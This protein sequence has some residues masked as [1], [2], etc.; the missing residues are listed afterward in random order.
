MSEVQYVNVAYDVIANDLGELMFVMMEVPEGEA[1]E[2]NIKFVYDGTSKAMFVRSSGQIARLPLLEPKIC[3]MLADG[4]KKIY[5]LE[6]AG[7]DK[8]DV[9]YFAPIEVLNAP[10]PI[11][12]LIIEGNVFEKDSIDSNLN[13][14]GKITLADGVVLEGNFV[15]GKL[16]GKGKMTF[17]DGDIYEGDFVDGI[18]QGKGKYT[19]A[20][21]D[22]RE[23]DF[24]DGVMNGKGK[25][26]FADGDMC[27]G[28]FVNGKFHGKAKITNSDGSVIECNFVDGKM[29]G[30][31]NLHGQQ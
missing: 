23:G 24:V 1:A 14:D 30:E 15:D 9:S 4:R 19:Q 12:E 11:P 25:Y 13:G 5:V 6:I 18:F 28:N 27:E 31:V 3:N 16:N 21:G 17:A 7:E 10:L 22:V 2:D 29:V 8:D 20:D 26:T